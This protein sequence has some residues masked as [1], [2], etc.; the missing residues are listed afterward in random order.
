VARRAGNIEVHEATKQQA[1]KHHPKPK[2]AAQNLGK[3][4]CT[5]FSHR[6]GYAQTDPHHEKHSQ[7]VD[8]VANQG[9][10]QALEYFKFFHGVAPI[11]VKKNSGAVCGIYRPIKLAVSDAA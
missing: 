4:A 5:L 1:V 2:Q 9:Q 11:V 3:N 10:V 6:P 7:G 8:G